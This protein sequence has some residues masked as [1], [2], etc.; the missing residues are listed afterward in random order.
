MKFG[1]VPL[2]QAEGAVLA[3]SLSAGGMALRKGH[4]L[5]PADLEALAGVIDHVTVARLEPGDIAENEAAHALASALNGV[6]VRVTEAF[7]GRANLIAQTNG[8]LRIG[9]DVAALN[10]VDEAITLATLPDY[11]RVGAGQMLATVKIIPYAVP[12]ALVAQAIGATQGVFDVHPFVLTSAA[13]ILTETPSLKKSLTAKADAI[14]RQRLS[15]LGVEDVT[16]TVLPHETGAVADALGKADADLVLVL[17]GSATSDRNDVCPAALNAAGG[18]VHRFG[19]PVDP[20]NLLFIGALAGRP[21]IGLPG[22]VRSPAL[23]GADWVLERIVAG[24]EVTGEDIASMGVGGLL[25]EIPSR[26]QSRMRP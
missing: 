24:L 26:P 19:M 2:A 21:V 15:A 6:G 11:A 17:G 8:V 13:L 20:G 16:T 22:C 25:K 9:T 23:N 14:L 5:T 10:S 4:V 7:T 12:G 1:T 18:V 3:H